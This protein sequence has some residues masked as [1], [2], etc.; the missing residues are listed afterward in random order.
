M[1]KTDAN[2]GLAGAP[3]S[4]VPA[5]PPVQCPRCGHQYSPSGQWRHYAIGL[6]ECPGGT[7]HE[8]VRSQGPYEERYEVTSYNRMRVVWASPNAPAQPRREGGVE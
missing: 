7:L 6:I 3:G 1:S 2:A 4:V 5:Y 8:H